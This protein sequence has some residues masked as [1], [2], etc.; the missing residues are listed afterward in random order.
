[1]RKYLR[2]FAVIISKIKNTK[3]NE[4]HPLQLLIGA[5]ERNYDDFD[6]G[7]EREEMWPR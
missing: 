4:A 7:K 6:L 5:G 3:R 1:M 2:L